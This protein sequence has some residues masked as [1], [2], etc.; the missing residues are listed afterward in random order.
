[1]QQIKNMEFSGERP[2]FASH[3]LQ[4][5]NVVIH[6][7]EYFFVYIRLFDCFPHGF[8]CSF[9]RDVIQY[10]TIIRPSLFGHFGVVDVIRKK[11]LVNSLS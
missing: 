8:L 10:V 4:L 2:L 3:D 9:Q 1:M 7:G 11:L 5:D 6:V